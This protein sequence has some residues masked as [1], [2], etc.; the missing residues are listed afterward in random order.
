L[1]NRKKKFE[2]YTDSKAEAEYEYNPFL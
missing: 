2:S 1:L